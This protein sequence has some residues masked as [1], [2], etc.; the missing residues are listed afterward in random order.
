[1]VVLNANRSILT[2]EGAQGPPDFIVEILSP[3]T[4][5]LDSVNKKRV[6]SRL[7]VKELWIIDPEPGAIQIHRFEERADDPCKMF[8]PG[9]V[10]ESPL[11]PGFSIEVSFIFLRG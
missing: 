10:I 4:R 6:Y 8:Y 9:D 5:K 2:D 3:K 11:L 1:L 7:G